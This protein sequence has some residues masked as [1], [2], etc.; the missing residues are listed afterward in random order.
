MNYC[1]LNILR[2]YNY[3]YHKFNNLYIIMSVHLALV[4][5]F[6]NNMDGLT[7]EL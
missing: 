1:Y 3:Y 5:K 2:N 6:Y 7:T 4:S